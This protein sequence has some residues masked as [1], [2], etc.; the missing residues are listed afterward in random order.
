MSFT[1]EGTTVSSKFANAFVS[2]FL[3]SAAIAT[4]QVAGR[5][6]GS[7]VD[8]SGAPIPNATVR[9]LLEGGAAA[10]VAST[11]NG[12]GLFLFPSIR[13]ETYDVIVEANGFRKNAVRR[14]KITAS[15]E[16]P[17]GAVKL[18]LGAVTEV[19]EVS[20]LSQVVQTTNAEV[21]STITNEQ[22]R[23][24]PTINRS[25]IALLLTQAGVTTNNR[26]ATTINGL[27]VSFVNVTLDG[28]NIQDNFI[29][30]NGVDF[31][32]NLLLLDQVAEV[33][34]GI[35]NN[36][37]SQGGGSAQINFVTP[38]GTNQYHGSLLW[39]NR[40]NALAANTW[41]NNRDRIARPFL[42]QNQFGGSLGGYVIKDKLFFYT[43][44][45][46]LRLR[47]QSSAN[48]TI[49]SP[50][51]RNGIYTYFAAGQ[52]RKVNVLQ[53]AGLTVDPAAKAL[54]DAVPSA[55][56]INNFRLGDSSE[57]LLRNTAG[58]SFLVR[59][60]RTRDNV[61]GKLD[62][63]LNNTNN[64][65]GTYTWNRDILDR[66]DQSNDYSLVPKVGNDSAPRLLSL[67]WR[68]TPA[69]T[70]TNE[71]RGGF[72]RTT[73]PFATSETFPSAIAAGL[74]YSNPLNTFRA[75]GRETN[76]YNL[77]DNATTVKGKHTLQY[78]F[79][80]QKLIVAPYNDAGITPVY[81]L[82]ISAN[83]PF[84]LNSNQLPGISA[85]DLTGANNLLAN[86]AGL[87]SASTQTFNVTS[88]DSGY[89]NG[90][91]NL[92]NFRQS[93]WSLY[94]QDS[95]KVTQRLSLILGM[96]YEFYTRVDERDALFLLPQD[97]T[98]GNA[99]SILLGN[100]TY[101]FAGSAVGRPGTAPTRITSRP[102]SALLM[103]SSAT[104]RPPSAAAIP[105]TS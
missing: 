101:D 85:A 15:Q 58:Y 74:I 82:G 55:D 87:L 42:N 45:E 103:T 68:W 52:T 27:R 38:S 67:T 26:S 102:T 5:L 30:T 50:D 6:S 75:Q 29:R 43:N 81:T 61:T 23:R 56:K 8:P 94:A 20:A 73:A 4:A 37:L 92:R 64:F 104:A 21:A 39:T 88:R 86:V 13:P 89:V 95:W 105:L 9:L 60:N 32:P 11:S 77:Q 31:Q 63:Y 99:R 70:T 57:A 18:E 96:R 79:Q 66:P 97:V 33:N 17:L 36:N 47:Q 1:Y 24:L 100:P 78:G 71:L 14:V 22:L 19:V 28:I 93:N 51:A 91:T 46:G 44:Y 2:I 84:G 3:A 12:E 16:T 98:A 80:F 35:S 41:F 49:L 34:V 25:P 59:N 76:T 69:P 65:S 90:A 83:S 10:V 48:R 62:Y 7:V 54:I 72:N 53:A 40:N